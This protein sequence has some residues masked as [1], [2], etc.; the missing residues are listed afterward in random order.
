MRLWSWGSAGGAALA[1]A[2]LLVVSP[3]GAALLE[4]P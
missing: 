1:V 4:T 3:A 2:N